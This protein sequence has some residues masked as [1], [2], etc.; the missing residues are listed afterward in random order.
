MGARYSCRIL[1]KLGF[2][3]DRFSKMVL[4]QDFVKIRAVGAEFHT[5]GRTV[6]HD[7]ANSRFS[8]FGER[9]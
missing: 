1:V 3:L 2:S 7:E 9:L 5:D 6:G 4:I 8:Q